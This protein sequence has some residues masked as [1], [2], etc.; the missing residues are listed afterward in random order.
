MNTGGGLREFIMWLSR[1][2]SLSAFISYRGLCG[3][4]FWQ[5]AFVSLEWREA[6]M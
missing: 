3:R 5:A 2:S 1:G 6:A 4:K